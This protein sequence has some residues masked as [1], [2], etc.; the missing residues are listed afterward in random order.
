MTRWAVGKDSLDRCVDGRWGRSEARR[1]EGKLPTG[2]RQE[3]LIPFLRFGGRRQRVKGRGS[4][5]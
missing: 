2:L 3:N 4:R 1:P 5:V